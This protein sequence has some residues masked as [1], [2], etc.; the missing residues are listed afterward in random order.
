MK[1]LL[2]AGAAAV[3]CATGAHADSP[4]ETAKARRA[5]YTLLGF[6][7]APLAEMAQGKTA[8]DAETARQSAQDMLTLLGYT[9]ADLFAP[10]TSTSEL[11]GETRARPALW[12]DMPGVQEKGKALHDAVVELDAVAGDGLDALRPAVGKLGGTCKA[13]HDDY[14]AADF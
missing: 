1:K 12:E 14:R 8:Y 10:G 2:L 9:T 6:E 13:C 7:M 3:I 11:P 5:F 4:S